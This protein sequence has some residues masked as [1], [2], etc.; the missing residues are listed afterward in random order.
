[1]TTH[2]T[3]IRNY[4]DFEAFFARRTKAAEAYASGDYS[5]LAPLV[6]EDGE[7]SFHSPGGDSVSGARAVADRYRKDA[8]GF[9]AG[10]KSRFEVLQR[11]VSGDVGFWTGFQVATVQP[12]ASPAPVELRIRVTEVFR[13]EGGEWKM[14]HRHADIGKR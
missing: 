9:R 8:A 12:E 14:V 10:G 1:M 5:P 4:S 6:A 13:K 3:D 2:S 11:G 7:A